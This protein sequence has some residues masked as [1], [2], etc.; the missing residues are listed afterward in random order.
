VNQYVFRYWQLAT[1]RF[2]PTDIKHRA[3]LYGVQ[4][5]SLPRIERII[6][7]RSSKIIIINDEKDSN[8]EV[9]QPI[10]QAAF[11]SILPE[12]SMFEI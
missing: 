6:R 9:A 10:I 4:D 8:Y 2:V 3:A 5:W 7:S 12:K 11:E 1:G